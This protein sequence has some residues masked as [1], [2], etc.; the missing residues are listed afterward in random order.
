MQSAFLFHTEFSAST[1]FSP[2]IIRT[3]ETVALDRDGVAK[4]NAVTISFVVNHSDCKE[5][6]RAEIS[7]SY[8]DNNGEVVAVTEVC[9]SNGGIFSLVIPAERVNPEMIEYTI[10]AYFTDNTTVSS[11]PISMK[12]NNIYCEILFFYEVGYYLRIRRYL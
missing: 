7:Y 9:E 12:Y 1:D 8:R 11:S 3:D 5:V 6:D 10:H 4:N 2:S